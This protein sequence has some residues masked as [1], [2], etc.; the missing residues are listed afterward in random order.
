MYRCDK[1]FHLDDL[2]KL[3]DKFDD[4]A[5]VLI[6]GKRVEFH[7]LNENQTKLLKKLDVTLPNQHKTGGFSA[8]RFERLRNEKINL[9]VMKIIELMIKFYT[10]DGRFNCIDLVIAGPAEMKDLVKENDL[11]KKFF[12]QHLTLSLVVAEITDQTIYQVVKIIRNQTKTENH[13]DLLEEIIL[14]PKQIDSIVFGVEDVIESYF[15]GLLKEIFVSNNSEYRDQILKSDIK[16]KIHVISDS[17]FVRKYGELV[18]VKYYVD[19]K[20]DNEI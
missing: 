9:F 19:I 7:L 6:S 15:S 14:D 16:T 10:V 17:I 4:R 12:R 20:Y 8:S 3:Y 5:L 1:K 11:F 13:I 18:G 2:L